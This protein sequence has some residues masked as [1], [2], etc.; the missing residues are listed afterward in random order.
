MPHA[1]VNN[2]AR[3][4]RDA[5]KAYVAGCS[6]CAHAGAAREEIARLDTAEDERNYNAA[7]GNR[8]ALKAYV[9]ER[10]PRTDWVTLKSREQFNNNRQASPPPFVDRTWLFV[11]DVV[12]EQGALSP[13]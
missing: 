8:D 1:A 2:A 5:L 4:N 12:R 3:G 10:K 11:N 6:V 13:A 7:R 9:A